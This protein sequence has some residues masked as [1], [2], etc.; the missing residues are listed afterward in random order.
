MTLSRVPAFVRLGTAPCQKQEAALRVQKM[1]RLNHACAKQGDSLSTANSDHARSPRRS[2]RNTGESVCNSKLMPKWHPSRCMLVQTAAS[3]WL[4][5]CVATMY[6]TGSN[7][8]DP[9]DK[10]TLPGNQDTSQLTLTT[11]AA[12]IA[13]YHR[14]CEC[15]QKVAEHAESNRQL[16]V[17]TF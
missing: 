16:G 15:C 13:T 8:F 9:F 14:S 7:E 6:E 3:L 12:R 17:K 10:H 2:F 5:S 11:L 4:R 1:L